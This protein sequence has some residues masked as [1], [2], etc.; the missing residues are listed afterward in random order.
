MRVIQTQMPGSGRLQLAKEGSCHCAG[1]VRD[2]WFPAALYQFS[3]KDGDMAGKL[4]QDN[5]KRGN[6]TPMLRWKCVLEVRST[7]CVRLTQVP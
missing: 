3:I 1:D 7:S 4:L 5:K 2:A 6:R